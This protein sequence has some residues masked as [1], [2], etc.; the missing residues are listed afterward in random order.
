MKSRAVGLITANLEAAANLIRLRMR[1]N[2]GHEFLVWVQDGQIMLAPTATN[3]AQVALRKPEQVV[4]TYVL[5][6]ED[7][8]TG[9]K[10]F[11]KVQWIVDDLTQHLADNPIRETA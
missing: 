6:S 9:E 2:N 11:L 7:R 5:A 8:R 3:E 4:N 10:S 1:Y